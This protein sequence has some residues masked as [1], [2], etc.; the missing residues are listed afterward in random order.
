VPPVAS[1][2]GSDQSLSGLGL[3][4]FTLFLAGALALGVALR[5]END[6]GGREQRVQPSEAA[7]KPNVVVLMTDDQTLAQ[8]RAM[9]YTERLL[10]RT[11]LSFDRF[12]VTDPLSSPSR[13]TFL[14]G[15]YAHNSGV[16]S[17]REPKAL[18]GLDEENTLG[19]W[20][21]KAG[22]R[23]AFVG[24]YLNGYGGEAGEQVPPG[25]SEWHALVDPTTQDYYDYT[26]NNNGELRR[27][28]DEADDYKTRVLGHLA[29]DAINHAT[30]GER[31]LF[32]YVGFNAPHAPS[33]PAPH[34]PRSFADAKAPRTPGFDEANVDDKPSFIRDRPPLD[35]RALARIDSRYRRALAS[36]QEVD[37]QIA[38]IVEQL[39]RKG[40]LG[41]TYLLFTS[42]NGYIDGEHRVEFGKRLP[43]EASARVPLL[44]RGPGIPGGETSDA[45]VGN[46]DLAPTIAA[47]ADAEPTIEADGRSLLPFAEHPD[48]ENDRPLLIESL[49]RDRSAY[50]GF[51]YEAIR[52]ARWLYA[53][54]STGD[55]ELYDLAADPFELESRAGA[56]DY[57]EVQDALAAALRRLAEC[58]GAR[59]CSPGLPRLPSP[60]RG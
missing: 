46:L 10:A 58:R 49:V 34:D 33:T 21:Q 30:R 26:V 38:R 35:R 25:W 6:G 29:V 16:V 5:N 11:G 42:D 24:E 56:P 51:P 1:P 27:Y 36:L 39:R 43:Y 45:L 12:Y 14:T 57:A 47:I 22:Y 44:V 52:A 8:M 54:Y 41:N 50:Y 20:L 28:G 18:A 23:T 37:R 53:R 48:R 7:A 2:A 60:Q 55:E 40:Q 59:E 17:N 9:P 4:G 13:A 31:P 3:A 15:Q 32:L 19:V